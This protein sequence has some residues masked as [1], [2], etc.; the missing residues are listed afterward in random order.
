M[1]THRPRITRIA[2]FVIQYQNISNT[3]KRRPRGRLFLSCFMIIVR[4]RDRI[5]KQ[6][7]PAAS[8]RSSAVRVEMNAGVFAPGIR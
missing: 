5:V 8:Y 3:R 4:E 7:F 6:N 2:E 1:F